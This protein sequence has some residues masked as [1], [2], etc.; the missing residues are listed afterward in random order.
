MGGGFALL[1]ARNGFD[2]AAVNYG[3]GPRHPEEALLGA[4]PVVG[5]FGKKDRTLPGAA[6][7]LQATLESLGIEHD[8]KEFE[9]AG[10]A[11][12][13]DAE[14]RPSAAAAPVPVMGIKP[15]PE[16]APEAWKRSRTTSPGT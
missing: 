8:V 3:R 5:N 13:N 11:F 4:C 7:K 1:V 2:A 15:N 6:A 10:H 12:M 14:E 9:N 16:A